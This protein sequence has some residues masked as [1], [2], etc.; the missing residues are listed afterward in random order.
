M[1]WFATFRDGAFF[2]INQKLEPSEM[3]GLVISLLI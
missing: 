1:N 2:N 3:N